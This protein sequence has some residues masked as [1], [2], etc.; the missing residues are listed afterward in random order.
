MAKPYTSNFK[1][2]TSALSGIAPRYLLEIEH[3]Q[4][5]VPVRVVNDNQD[6]TRG[7]FL[8]LPG[9]S[10]NYASTP[11]SAAVSITGDIDI[12]VKVAADDWT[13]AAIQTFM[14]KRFTDGNRSWQ[15][16]ISGGSSGRLVFV[17]SE[18]GIGA[19]EKSFTSSA[20]PGVADGSM[21]WVRVTF[22]V[23]DGA[24]NH[25]AKFYTSDDGATWAQLGTTQTAV[26]VASIF[27][28]ACV[29]AIGANSPG[30]TEILAGK[31]YYAELR[32]G[33]DGPVVAKFDPAKAAV[34]DLL[35]PSDT[36]EVWT[37]N[38]SGGLVAEIEAD[39][40]YIA[41]AFR[42][43]LPDDIAQQVP[44]ARLAIDNVGKELTQWLDA[45]NGGRG[46][47][48]RVMQVM[49][50]APDVLESDVT[51]DLVNVRQTMLQITGEL[52]YQNV[53]NLPASGINYRPDNT[54]PLF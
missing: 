10:G 11:D 13:P 38:Q 34:G 53:L 3:P 40:T 51:L 18:D 21:K 54:P 4:L 41:C 30:T 48:V 24:G 52:G 16:R 9:T 14:A 15:F 5:A 19:N 50:D 7:H 46:S 39:E 29:V 32:N 47:T 26:G 35:V 6:L 1:K 20:A 28:S 12:R 43:S 27:D 36:G 2:K 8:S 49:P 37:I 44:R 42:I 45:S 33:I 31:V 22:D 25:V 23:N 17:W